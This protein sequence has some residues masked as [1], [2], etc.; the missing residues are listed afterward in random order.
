MVT[1]GVH[2]QPIYLLKGGKKSSHTDTCT[3]KVKK[4]ATFFLFSNFWE[5][6]SHR[7]GS[8]YKLTCRIESRP[9]HAVQTFFLVYL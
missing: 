7:M 4:G 1:L 8:Y 9:F 5:N 2:F 3:C 6:F